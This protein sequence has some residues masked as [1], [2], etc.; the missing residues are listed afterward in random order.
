MADVSSS[1]TLHCTVGIELPGGQ[2]RPFLEYG[3]LFPTPQERVRLV[4][5]LRERN[6]LELRVLARLNG[7]PAVCLGSA[8]LSNIRLNAQGE[9]QLLV[10]MQSDSPEFAELQIQDELGKGEVIATFRLPQET[11]ADGVPVVAA[12]RVPGSEAID[13]LLER[14]SALEHELELRYQNDA[15]PGGNGAQDIS[16]HSAGAED[17]GHNL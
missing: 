12:P 15:R 8:R 14:V 17:A 11:S 5:K 3:T 9:A 6:R 16:R 7:Q 10:S 2:L 1:T 4:S 13:K